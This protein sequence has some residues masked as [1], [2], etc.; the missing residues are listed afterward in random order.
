MTIDT[1]EIAAR[2]YRNEDRTVF[3]EIVKDFE[4]VAALDAGC[5]RDGVAQAIA[6][7]ATY[8]LVFLRCGEVDVAFD[9][10]KAAEYV[11]STDA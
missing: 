2:I 11:D 5:V 4:M 9:L 10:A 8:F 3:V 1:T 6:R 7:G